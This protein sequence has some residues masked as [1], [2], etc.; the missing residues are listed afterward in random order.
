M[1]GQTTR[2]ERLDRQDRDPGSPDDGVVTT[3]RTYH[4]DPDCRHVEKAD[5][6]KIR[7]DL[8]RSGAQLRWLAPCQLCVLGG[9][10]E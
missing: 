2:E 4:D 8:D 5:A 9:L 7:D 3:Q 6:G 1:S 10:D